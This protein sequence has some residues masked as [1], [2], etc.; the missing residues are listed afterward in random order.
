MATRCGVDKFHSSNLYQ[1]M[2]YLTNCKTEPGETVKG[3]PVYGRAVSETYRVSGFD[4]SLNT[5]DMN[6]SL[7][8][9]HDEIVGIFSSLVSEMVLCDDN[10]NINARRVIRGRTGKM[11][12]PH[13][14]PTHV[15][16]APRSSDDL[17]V[18]DVD[19]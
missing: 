14:G 15:F 19:R 9:I 18:Y 17:P 6:H 11:F 16:K 1:M 5:I 12:V 13:V 2:S 3:M 8:K 7:E 10:T 4:I